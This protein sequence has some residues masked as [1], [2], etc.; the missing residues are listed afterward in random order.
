MLRNCSIPIIVLQLFVAFLPQGCSHSSPNERPAIAAIEGRGGKVWTDPEM[1][2]H[3]VRVV[4]L[5]GDDITDDDLRVLKDLPRLVRLSIGGR[6]TD[7]GLAHL[8]GLEELKFL[9]LTGTAISDAGLKELKALPSLEALDL[10]RTKIRGDGLGHL[11]EFPN[12]KTLDLMGTDVSDS[13]LAHIKGLTNLR[14]LNLER[15]KM[16]DSAVAELKQA[17]P[18]CKIT[19]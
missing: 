1:Q 14:S 18:E 8:R 6:I 11:K 17:L 5:L 10:A 19:K 3:P 9:F 4:Q 13:C 15:T 16:T 12:L 2:Y 7:A